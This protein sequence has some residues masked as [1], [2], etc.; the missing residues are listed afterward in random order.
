MHRILP[1]KLKSDSA[2]LGD[3]GSVAQSAGSSKRIEGTALI[4]WDPKREGEKL[5]AIDTDQITPA[6]DCVSESLDSLD[7]KWKEGAFPLPHARLPQTRALGRDVRHRRRSLRHRLVPRD[8]PGGA[9]SR[10][11]KRSG[12]SSSS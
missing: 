6:K 4:F 8:E 12:S 9:E 5:D 7:E 11:R 2:S 10:R 1:A 3:E